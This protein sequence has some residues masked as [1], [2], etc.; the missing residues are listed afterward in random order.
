MKFKRMLKALLAFAITGTMIWTLGCSQI[1]YRLKLTSTGVLEKISASAYPAF[2]DDM[3]LDGL[4]HGMIQSLAYFN[5]IPKDRTFRFGEHVFDTRHMIQTLEHFLTFI[6]TRPN[7]QNLRKFITDNYW[8][9]RSVGGKKSGQVLFTGY[10]E[11]ILS[12]L[13]KRTPEYRYP[14]YVRPQDIVSIDLSLFSKKYKGNTIV[15]RVADYKVI[16]YYDRKAIE[17]DDALDGKVEALAWINDPVDL[18]FLQVQGSGKIYLNKGGFLN[19]HYHMA[20]GHPYR[21]IGKLL[22]DQN[23]IPREK[24][25]MQAIRSYL[26]AHPDE[27]EEILNYNPSYVFFKTEKEA[28]I[29]YLEVTLTPGRS[30][31]SDRRIFPHGALGFIKVKKPLIDGSKKIHEWTDCSRFVLNQD[32]GGAIRGPGRA[33]L[34]WG[35]GPYAEI[36]AGHLRHRGEL[37]FIVL[38]PNDK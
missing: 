33:D 23:K 4:E 18:F 20:N 29:G 10:Y 27:I 13:N 16:P 12:G 17:S 5:R 22:I 28:P 11:P 37:Y 32:T 19:V 3:A 36:A 14:I 35:N 1:A 38:K 2:L 8:V 25:S 34:F 31:A 21:S 26:S 7:A 9:Y 6:R 15:G 24:M 30:I